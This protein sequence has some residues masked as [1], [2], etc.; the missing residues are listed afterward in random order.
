[1]GPLQ[2][3]QD[4]T[5]W[6]KDWCHTD[7]VSIHKKGSEKDCSNYCTISLI[8]HASKIMLKIIFNRINHKYSTKIPNE[9]AGVVSGRGT[10]GHIANIRQI[11]E[12]CNG[13]NTQLYM[14]FLDY[15]KAFDCVSHA[16]LW[17]IL[18][19][20]GFPFNLKKPDAHTVPR[21]R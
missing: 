8:A 17:E 11:I 21:Q 10:R 19:C 1:M 13:H 3:I 4:R 5:E 18:D 14:C 16:Q 6:P 2:E 15:S 7:Y 9:Q 12:K 20:M